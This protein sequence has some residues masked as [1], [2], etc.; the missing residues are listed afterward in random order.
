MLIGQLKNARN[1]M[2][3][4]PR[5]NMEFSGADSEDERNCWK[6]EIPPHTTGQTR[7]QLLHSMT[8]LG[9]HNK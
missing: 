5:L 4:R 1:K 2:Q 7:Q 6:T 8:D 9:V 3:Q